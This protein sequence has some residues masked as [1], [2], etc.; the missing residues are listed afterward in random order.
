MSV[1]TCRD[2]VGP[3]G[4]VL[5]RVAVAPILPSDAALAVFGL[6]IDR[7]RIVVVRPAADTLADTTVSLPPD[8]TF[9]DLDLR[10][11][12]VS[13][14]ESLDVT[15]EALSGTIPLFTG[16]GRL[17]AEDAEPLLDEANHLLN[18]IAGL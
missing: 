8:A 3:R 11:P 2:A 1:A 7:V 10:V 12:L 14:P 17:S 9:L 16:T 18:A 6:A 5:G 4:T 15:I 13:S